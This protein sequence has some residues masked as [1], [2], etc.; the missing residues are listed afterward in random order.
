MGWGTCPMR[1]KAVGILMKCSISCWDV[2]VQEGAMEGLV[3]I[4]LPRIVTFSFLSHL[5]GLLIFRTHLVVGEGFIFVIVGILLLVVGL[6][7]YNLLILHCWIPQWLQMVKMGFKVEVV[8]QEAVFLLIITISIPILW[9]LRMEVMVIRAVVGL[10][11][12]SDYGIING[13]I[14]RSK[15]RKMGWF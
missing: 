1:G 10:G 2:W 3:G 11:V 12:G 6:S 4:V 7:T 13:R 5:M 8:E 9:F 15:S 14:S